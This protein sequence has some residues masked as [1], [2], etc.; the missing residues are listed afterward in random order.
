MRLISRIEQH[1]ITRSISLLLALGLSVLVL[2]L[3]QLLVN[4]EQKTSHAWL[5]LL[6]VGISICFIHGL[7]FKPRSILFSLLFSAWLA[8]SLLAISLLNLWYFV[9]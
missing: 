5:S 4:S 1:V 6:M 8:W 9:A 2:I 7:G 3:P